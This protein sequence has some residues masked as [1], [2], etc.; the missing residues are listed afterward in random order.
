MKEITLKILDLLERSVVLQAFITIGILAVASYIWVIGREM[1]ADLKTIVFVVLSF[2]MG[3]KVQHTVDANRTL[4]L[5][6]PKDQ[7]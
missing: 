3:S 4:R 6:T 2:W 1:P 5:N 7:K